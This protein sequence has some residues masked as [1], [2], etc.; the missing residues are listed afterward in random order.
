MKIK[1]QSFLP[2]ILFIVFIVSVF[3]IFAIM[4]N[5]SFSSF[6][7]LLLFL[8]LMLGSYFFV[9]SFRNMH[10]TIADHSESFTVENNLTSPEIES[11]ENLV[12]KNTD[13]ELDIKKILPKEKNNLELFSEELLKNMAGE[14]QFVQALLYF[15]NPANDLFKCVGRYAYFNDIPPTDFKAGETLPGQAVKNKQI[16]TLSNIPEN[17]MIIASGLGNGKPGFLTL[18]PLIFHDEAVGLI[19]FATF[20]PITGALLKNL[21][22]VSE[23]VGESISKF[24]KK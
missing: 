8:I 3:W 10:Q 11:K 19:E 15:K 21:Q 12:P 17:Y 23:K 20:T 24:I 7:Y 6:G 4:R 22:L 13:N 18:I 16:V 1:G 5:N 14:F 9:V 2:T